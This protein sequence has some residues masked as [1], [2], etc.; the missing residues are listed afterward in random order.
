MSLSRDDILVLAA[1]IVAAVVALLWWS[2]LPPAYWM[3]AVC[4]P[5]LAVCAAVSFASAGADVY[6]LVRDR[7]GQLAGGVR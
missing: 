7:I 5:V 6:R 3:A 2:G 4:V 1:V